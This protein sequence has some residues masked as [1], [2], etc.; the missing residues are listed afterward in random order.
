VSVVLSQWI[1]KLHLVSVDGLR[2]LVLIHSTKNPA[3]HILRFNHENAERAKYV[4]F[5]YNVEVTGSARFIAQ[6]PA[7][8]RVGGPLT[9]EKFSL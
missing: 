2:P 6:C 8:Y 7:G 9:E 5:P 3:A 4:L 1:L